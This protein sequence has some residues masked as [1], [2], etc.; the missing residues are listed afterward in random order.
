MMRPPQGDC[1]GRES[2]ASQSGSA[3]DLR[4]ASSVPQPT[5]IQAVIHVAF[6]AGY[7]QGK[8]ER[9]EIE[10]E[11]QVQ[12]RIHGRVREALGMAKQFASAK[13]PAWAAMIAECG[14]PE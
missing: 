10:I 9:V 8:A 1:P 5:N 6:V 14:E 4:L 3:A 2:E 7:E 12:A 11:D 13:G